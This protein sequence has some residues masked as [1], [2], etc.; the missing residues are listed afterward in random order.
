MKKHGKKLKKSRL[1]TKRKSK[2]PIK[3]G[4]DVSDV[5]PINT[6]RTNK[7]NELIGEIKDFIYSVEAVNADGKANLIT[8]SFP[9]SS[10]KGI[11]IASKDRL[12]VQL[13]A[14]AEL[15]SKTFNEEDIE[16]ILL[17]R[18]GHNL[19][20]DGTIVVKKDKVAKEIKRR[21]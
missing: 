6:E 10:A 11:Y 15:T 9:L 13:E 17:K 1:I 20:K 16:R 4:L 5:F 19:L 2:L 12:V 18:Q 14:D 7:L 21:K 8:I 3:K